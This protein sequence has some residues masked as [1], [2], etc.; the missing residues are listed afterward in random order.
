[1]TLREYI[2]SL[3]VDRVMGRW[4][5]D[6]MTRRR[7]SHSYRKPNRRSGRPLPD[8]MDGTKRTTPIRPSNTIYT[9]LPAD[10]KKKG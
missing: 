9:T 1:M 8:F 7:I 4:Y 10:H 5:T 2:S 3:G 6:D